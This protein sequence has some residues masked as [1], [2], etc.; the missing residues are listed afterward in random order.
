MS[1]KIKFRAYDKKEKVMFAEGFN[2][3]GE[4]TVFDVLNQHIQGNFIERLNDIDVMQFT[5]LL[6]KNGKEVYE[7]DILKGLTYKDPITTKHSKE[8]LGVVKWSN[9]FG[10]AEYHV[11]SDLPNGYRTFLT[12]NRSE[13]V[14]NIYENPELLA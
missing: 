8:I 9:D 7:G 14:G 10:L 2:V 3:I 13:V 4:Y 11:S 5:G 6:D 1:R 12:M